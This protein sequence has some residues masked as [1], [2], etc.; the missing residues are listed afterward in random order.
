[1][2]MSKEQPQLVAGEIW[3]W[4]FAGREP[5]IILFNKG[6]LKW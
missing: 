4:L 1:M 2:L 3:L 5:I 6:D